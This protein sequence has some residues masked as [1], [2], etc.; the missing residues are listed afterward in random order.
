MGVAGDNVVSTGCR[1]GFEDTVIVGV[2]GNDTEVSFRTDNRKSVPEQPDDSVHLCF[3]Q[4]EWPT[5]NIFDLFHKRR[6][7]VS[8]PREFHPQTLAGRVENWR[9]DFRVRW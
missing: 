5:Q 1:G 7:E 2:G 4:A 9:A 3:T 8:S 6:R